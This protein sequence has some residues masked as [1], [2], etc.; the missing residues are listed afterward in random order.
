MT[1]HEADKLIKETALGD[2]TA[3]ETLYKAMSKP[4]YFYVLRLVGDPDVAEDV[5]Q[6]TFVSVMRSCASYD[7]REKGKSWI[8]TIAKNRATD[9]LRRANKTV[10]LEKSENFA[11]S[12]TFTDEAEALLK[13]A[14]Q[15]QMERFLLQ[16]QV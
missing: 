9:Y 1:N 8:F 7:E 16:E 13:E 10:S 2:K 14:I 15:E 11:E 3:L 12:M 4:V 6:D 5:M